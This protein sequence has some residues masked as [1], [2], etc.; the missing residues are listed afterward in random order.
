MGSHYCR[1]SCWSEYWELV[2]AEW[3]LY[4]PLKAQGAQRE[5]DGMEGTKELKER[6]ACCES[7][8]FQEDMAAGCY[9]LELSLS[10]LLLITCRRPEQ[11]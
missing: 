3:H 7:A 6:I 8:V 10:Q 1:D 5:I 2:V 9:I 11:D 4:Q